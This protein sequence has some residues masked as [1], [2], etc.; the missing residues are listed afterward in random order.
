[1][2]RRL[3]VTGILLA[4][5]SVVAACGDSDDDG[6]ASPTT[7]PSGDA[8]ID[9]ETLTEGL[10]AAGASVEPGGSVSQPFFSVDAA[11]IVVNGEDVQVFVY[12]DAATADIEAQTISPD[13]HVIGLSAVT[14]CLIPHFYGTN[15]L[16]VL[17]VGD[18]PAMTDLLDAVLGPEFAG[19]WVP[20]TPC[21]DF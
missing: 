11:L 18:T 13:G 17:Y 21:P 15:S 16:M 2:S 6:G 4:V 7:S 3:R 10:L 19:G 20:P 5:V 1:M 12:A 9:V 8:V 14:W